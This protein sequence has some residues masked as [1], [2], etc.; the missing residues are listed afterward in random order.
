MSQTMY[1]IIAISVLVALLGLAVFLFLHLRK[2][3]VERAH[4]ESCGN[5]SCPIAK[6][7]EEKR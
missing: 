4:C 7:Q 5:L 3:K 1:L 6:A 2:D